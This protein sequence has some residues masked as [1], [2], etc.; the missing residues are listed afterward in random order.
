MLHKL[1]KRR[2]REG[3]MI[4]DSPYVHSNIFHGVIPIL[5]DYAFGPFQ[6]TLLCLHFPP[7]H[8]VAV[9]IEL[10]SL[11]IEAMSNLMADDK[12]D[13]TIVHVTR[14]LVAEERALQDT[15][16]EFYKK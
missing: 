12:T 3:E 4:Q 2:N 5:M 1:D 6:I 14:P 10:S 9:L 13:S 16:G 7:V 11:I 15:R 8:E